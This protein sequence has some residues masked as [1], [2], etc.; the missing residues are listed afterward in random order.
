MA[1]PTDWDV[2]QYRNE[3]E[4]PEHWRLCRAFILAHKSDY[5]EARLVCLAQCFANME[6]LGCRY[7]DETMQLVRELSAGIADDYRREKQKKIQ[8][9]FVRASDAAEAKVARKRISYDTDGGP[10]AKSYR[11]CDDKPVGNSAAF[12]LVE[13][14]DVSVDANPVNRLMCSSGFCKVPVKFD[15]VG[16]VCECRV[17]GDHVGTGRRPEGTSNSAKGSGAKTAK[18]L[19]AAEA[20]ATLQG[21]CYTIRLKTKILAEEDVARG[22]LVAAEGEAAQKV[23]DGVGGKLLAM[24]GWTGGGLGKQKQG[25]T[26]PVRLEEV[27]GRQG[28]GSEKRTVTR[29]FKDKTELRLRA[30]ASKFQERDLS[31]SNEFSNEERKEIH[32]IAH[33]FGLK[34]KSYGKGEERFLVVSHKFNPYHLLQYLL[35]TGGQTD[36]YELIPPKTEQ[37]SREDSSTAEKVSSVICL[38]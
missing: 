30:Y 16:D 19:A 11:L 18:T 4:P 34:S 2:E 36:K 27:V 37:S 25:I 5:P 33:R 35:A 3:H 20:L 9:T 8:R 15:M 24:M 38:T 6:F 14:G 29:E 21:Q 23:A 31:F 12:I 17:G 7:P 10:S 28:L 1:H 13:Y 22:E 32:S 26:E